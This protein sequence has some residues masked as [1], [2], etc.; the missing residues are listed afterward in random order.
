LNRFRRHALRPAVLLALAAMLLG[1]SACG[2]GSGSKDPVP[3]AANLIP[4]L[5]SFGYTLKDQGKD[6]AVP[7]HSE[8]AR[9][10][11]QGARGYQGVQIRLWVFDNPSDGKKLFDQYAAQ[12]VHPPPDFLGAD[13]AQADTTSPQ[14]GEQRKSYVTAKS[15]HL[16]DRVYT[17]LYRSGHV[18]LLTQVIDQETVDLLPTRT[19]VAQEV[20][21]RAAT[22]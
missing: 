20:F 22:P 4:D 3:K 13:V 19:N 9:A 17:D 7:P 21:K 12:L 15:D 14:I 1:A 2:G 11:Y 10:L 16:G 8:S 5:S 18:V 6:P